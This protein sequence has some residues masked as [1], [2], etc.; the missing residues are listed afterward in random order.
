MS[1]IDSRLAE[2]KAAAAALPEEDRRPPNDFPLERFAYDRSQDAFWDMDANELLKSAKAVNS[3]I[4]TQYWED[5]I[6]KKGEPTKRPPSETLADPTLNFTVA[7][8]TWHPAEP[9]IIRD[10]VAKKGGLM[11]VPGKH[12][13]NTYRAPEYEPTP[14]GAT[15]EP[16][17]SHLELIYP[18]PE[19]REHLLNWFAHTVQHPGVKINHGIVL[20]GDHGIGKDSLLHPIRLAV[21]ED[22]VESVNPEGLT[23]QFNPYVRSVLVTVDELGTEKT[24][25]AAA[26]LYNRTKTMLA[27]P[28]TMLSMNLKGLNLM[29]VP[30]VI[31]VVFT[32]NE[33]DALRIP[34]S[35]RRLF[36]MNSPLR[37]A[38]DVV[39]G[40]RLDEA[41]FNALWGSMEDGGW[42]AVKDWL[43]A[44]DLSTFNPK[45][46]PPQTAAKREIIA[47]TAEARRSTVDD[48]L[49]E[50]FDSEF[51]G[52]P[53][54]VLFPNDLLAY[55]KVANVFDDEETII[56]ELKSKRLRHIMRE[57]GYAFVGP[58]EGKAR[59]Q[60]KAFRSRTAYVL[61]KVSELEREEAVAEALAKRPIAFQ[62]TGAVVGM[63]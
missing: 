7:G 44:R 48:L 35:D 17:L 49:D 34:A 4:H 58:P 23:S 36:I 22:N 60:K 6:D 15:H 56:D 18:D 3:A 30:N 47:S 62:A 57:R 61:R 31:K 55:V 2:I 1:D 33:P 24:D 29:H 63:N 28:P 45:K 9:M 8:A 51:D 59:W 46:K 27:A 26:S 25:Y 16:W 37:S 54:E 38:A 32:T 52:A 41:Y 11:P 10:R 13:Y 40:G 12:M 5:T 21:G 39:E 20:A 50:L 53:P 42:L 14:A 19:E 43:M